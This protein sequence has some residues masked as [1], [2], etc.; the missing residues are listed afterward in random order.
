MK[1]EEFATKR[2]P[3]HEQLEAW[4]AWYGSVFDVVCPRRSVEKGFPATHLNWKL[5]GL[6]VGRVCAPAVHA[7][8][9]KTLIRR[10]PVD[11]WVIAVND[12][13]VVEYTLRGRSMTVHAGV[14][15]VFSMAEEMASA[16]RGPDSVRCFFY[17]SR[18][19][20]GSIASLLDAASGTALATPE[21]KLL[22]DY[23]SLLV[24]N[25]PDLAPEDGSRLVT[26]VE[27]MIGACLAPSED[28]RAAA[29]KPIDLTLRERVRRTV[30]TH[31]HSPLLGPEK[32]CREAATSRSRL[33]RLFENEGGV[34]HYIQ[35][36]RLSESFTLLSD[37]TNLVPVAKIAEA[38]CFTDASSFSRAFRRRF[39]APPRDSLRTPM[40]RSFPW[41][42]PKPLD[43]PGN[44][45][46]YIG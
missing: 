16:R 43:Q 32:L 8:R 26:A 18:D 42:G 7:G 45:L 27:A 35:R 33:Y 20:F 3:R 21:G 23:M 44:R 2:L 40:T 28:R 11:H 37:A 14:P 25:L 5:G 19:T 15:L 29:E 46:G 36:Q 9:T 10:N 34:A 41:S 17:L 30:R 4:G 38:L 22:A 24:C 6:G 12:G 39:G 31:L 1:P 13:G